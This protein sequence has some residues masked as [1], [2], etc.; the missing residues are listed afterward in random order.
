M[1]DIKNV[2]VFLPILYKNEKEPNKEELDDILNYCEQVLVCYK[3][4]PLSL[5]GS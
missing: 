5:F 2:F 4:H 1:K 3:A